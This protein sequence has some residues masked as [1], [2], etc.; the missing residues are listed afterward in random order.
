[1]TLTRVSM[2]CVHFCILKK[3][4]GLKQSNSKTSKLKRSFGK[5]R[6]KRLCAQSESPIVELS[7]R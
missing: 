7:R 3:L 1:M 6:S 4:N 2:Y 5:E